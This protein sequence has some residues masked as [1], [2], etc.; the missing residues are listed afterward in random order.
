MRVMAGDARRRAIM[1]LPA[2]RARAFRARVWSGR[3]VLVGFGPDMGKV[4]GA[5]VGSGQEREWWRW[6]RPKPEKKRG[7]EGR[8]EKRGGG[9][10]PLCLSAKF[11]E[12]KGEKGKKGQG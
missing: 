7:R 6:P 10:P 2:W 8:R 4:E 11:Q 12:R 1:P 9:S 3:G 5:R